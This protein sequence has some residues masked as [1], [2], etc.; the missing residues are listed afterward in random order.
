MENSNI[1]TNI[2]TESQ[3]QQLKRKKSN[4]TYSLTEIIEINRKQR[5]TAENKLNL[6]SLDSSQLAFVNYMNE[7]KS[8]IVL[9]QSSPG[10]GK[11]YTLRIYC[12][13]KESE[14]EVIIF[15]RDL[16]NSFNTLC[17]TR[18][19]A[20]FFMQCFDFKQY[21]NYLSIEN[22]LN[23]KMTP[24]EL[25]LIIRK[26]VSNFS[27]DRSKTKI[28]DEY[29]FIPKPMLFALLL[30]FKH[31]NIPAILCGDKH[32]LQTIQKTKLINVS[33][34][35]MT[36]KFSDKVFNFST[37]HRCSDSYHN[38]VIEYLSS[39]SCDSR[40]DDIG[41]S[42]IATLHQKQIIANW[43]QESLKNVFMASTHKNL[44]ITI[45]S[46]VKLY[47]IPYSY[48]FI[49]SSYQDPRINGVLIANGL[50][51]CK[52]VIEYEENNYSP[53]KFLPYIPLIIGAKYFILSYTED[54]IGTLLDI[55]YREENE[56][57]I[58]NA[59]TFL[60]NGRHVKVH[61][62]ATNKATFDQHLKFLLGEHSIGK[63]LN[64]PI[65]MANLMSMHMAQGRTITDN[66]NLIIS[67]ETTYQG[68]YVAE[69]RVTKIEQIFKVSIPHQLRYLLSSILNFPELC[70]NHQVSI[71]ILKMRIEQNYKIYEL[72]DSTKNNMIAI[73]VLDFIYSDNSIKKHE[74]RNSLINLNLPFKLVNKKEEN[75][76]DEEIYS[77]LYDNGTLILALS[78]LDDL[79]AFV[80]IHEFS[81]CEGNEHLNI[82]FQGSS[83]LSTFSN[84]LSNYASLTLLPKL[85]E[86]T[87]DFIELNGITEYFNIPINE[88]DNVK[89]T[90]DIIKNSKKYKCIVEVNEYRGLYTTELQALIYEKLKA[91]ERLNKEKMLEWLQIILS[92]IELSQQPP[93]T[94]A[95]KSIVSEKPTKTNSNVFDLIKS[96]KHRK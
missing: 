69:S 50:Y 29:T 18:T 23:S 73:Q 67:E 51:K 90:A 42:I 66:L 83:N 11:T 61:K 31:Y 81:K 60:L 5:K 75:V 49:E 48:Y 88:N 85:L 86:S 62:Q 35:T 10:T 63:L 27:V 39:L 92:N 6:D 82:L 52:A 91:N 37:N 53:G 12:S 36:E 2:N 17:D 77:M 76:K 58:P 41:F 56:V 22:F 4:K 46:L 15:K 74:I 70:E 14:V 87:T 89:K 68:F 59:L 33:S 32:Q 21:F 65:S 44:S 19:N 30:S 26:L 16:L 95:S 7:T 80:W 25:F 8:P 79:D 13:M 38:Q 57:K 78:K 84:T 71:D 43:E 55:E 64:F 40:L 28:F 96:I 94:Y 24:L 54:S 9:I 1:T 20:Q 34:Y 45:D 47:M 93:K 72:I 3:K